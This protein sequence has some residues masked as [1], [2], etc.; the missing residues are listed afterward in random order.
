MRNAV[1]VAATSVPSNRDWFGPAW[2]SIAWVVLLASIAYYVRRGALHYL[3]RY[4]PESFKAFWP[5]RIL[6]R[7]HVACAIIMIF[8]GPFQFWT[9]TNGTVVAMYPEE[10]RVS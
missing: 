1:A 5:D 2:K 9:V 7:T 4:T 6:I 3:F 10:Y 8:T